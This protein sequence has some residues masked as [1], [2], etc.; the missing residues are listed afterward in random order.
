VSLLDPRPTGRRWPF[1]ALI[2]ETMF[3]GILMSLGCQIAGICVTIFVVKVT[4][5]EGIEWVF[6]GPVL[7]GLA[8]WAFVLPLRLR[9]TK[10]QRPRSV[11]GLIWTSIALTIVS[12]I[13][14]PLCILTGFGW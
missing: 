6:F 7:W 9:L 13:G 10:R 8:Q 5:S 11:R 12:V 4:R 14:L 3:T 2:G 1:P